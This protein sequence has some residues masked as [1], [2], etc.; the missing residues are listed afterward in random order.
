MCIRDSY[1]TDGRADARIAAAS[2]ADL[3]D[4]NLAGAV[5]GSILVYNATTSQF[6]I[7][8]DNNIKNKKNARVNIIAS[9]K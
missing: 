9:S 4:V 6:E 5:T 2:I 8:S 1:Y 7:G 3:S